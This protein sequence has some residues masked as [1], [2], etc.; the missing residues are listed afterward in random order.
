MCHQSACSLLGRDSCLTAQCVPCRAC[1]A[2][3]DVSVRT[4]E[5]PMGQQVIA[6]LHGQGAR[7]T[8]T[9]SC[10]EQSSSMRIN[11]TVDHG[12][13]K[14]SD[15]YASACVEQQD[16]RAQAG[17]DAVINHGL[18]G[19]QSSA[20]TITEYANWNTRQAEACSRRSVLFPHVHDFIIEQSTVRTILA[21][22]RSSTSAC[23]IFATITK[24]RTTLPFANQENIRFA[25]RNLPKE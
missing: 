20:D 11:R 17:D 5:R 18:G 9:V 12:N 16:G 10:I 7:S 25:I 21:H 14:P 8:S 19:G 24:A 1:K 13:G 15:A 6:P 23:Y 4:L 3:G 2:I 22:R